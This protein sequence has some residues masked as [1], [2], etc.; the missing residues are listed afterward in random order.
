M[1]FSTNR[2]YWL[3]M[4]IG[5]VTPEYPMP[6]RV[7]GGLAAYL[8]KVGASLV[9]RGNRVSVLVSSDKNARWEDQG[10]AIHEVRSVALPS[11]PGWSRYALALGPPVAQALTSR[12]LA[13]AV[14]AIHADA[15]FDIL[16]ASS[17]MAPGLSL[18]RNGRV[19]LVCRISS[20][21]RLVRAAYGRGTS[22]GEHIS[23][24][25]E[26]HQI[27][28]ADAVFS[29]SKRMADAFTPA[30]GGGI[31][32]IGTPPDLILSCR[33]GTTF[34]DAQLDGRAY[35]LFFGTL[36][37]I[38]GVDLIA[39][40]LP[41]ILTRNP[42]LACVFIG[43]DDGLPGGQKATEY[44]AARCASFGSRVL[45]HPAVAKELLYPVIARAQGVLM[46]SRI[47]NY[48]NACLEAQML[49]IPVIGTYRSSLD[50]LIVDGENG[51][52]AENGSASSLASAVNR[53]LSQGPAE[54]AAMRANIARHVAAIVAEDRIGR[55]LT[56]FNSVISDFQR[57]R[58]TGPRE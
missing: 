30:V 14:W 38:K 49:G 24:W 42:D 27:R 19:P 55:L 16:Q 8:R 57:V 25:F 28:R 21:S 39:D 40:A 33:F 20:H 7:D 9:R 48:P 31:E 2:D 15:P 34:L 32:V 46:P 50:E 11:L 53:L 4:H 37:R 5:F 26:I 12:R 10:V 54:R 17:Y 36:S 52:L 18:L 51:F 23:D 1:L 13:D 56:F 35:L 43:R 47:D 45:Y 58:P 6:G 22:V 29:P 41:E 44:I 3:L